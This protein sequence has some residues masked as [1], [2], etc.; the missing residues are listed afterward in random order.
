MRADISMLES[1]QANQNDKTG[2]SQM[3]VFN[4]RNA[5]KAASSKIIK[6][7]VE[8]NEIYRKAHFALLDQKE[9]AEEKINKDINKQY[10]ILKKE[11]EKREADIMS[12]AKNVLLPEVKK[13]AD[14]IS[15]INDPT[16]RSKE[17]HNLID[18][19]QIRSL[20]YQAIISAVVKE[21]ERIKR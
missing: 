18:A 12:H 6:D 11:Y 19:T 2:M 13:E 7:R 15:T 4:D 20:G 21:L 1:L 17:Y 8:H 16:E 3:A 10:D 5:V 9:A 14:R